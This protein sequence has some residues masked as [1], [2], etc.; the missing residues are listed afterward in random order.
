MTITV[1]IVLKMLAMGLVA[2]ALSGMVGIGG[3]VVLVPAMVIF[4][5]FAQKEAQGTPLAMLMFPVVI[6]SVINYYRS[7]DISM[8]NIKI[9]LMIG[10]G[11]IFGGYLGSKLAVSLPEQLSI[12]EYII[13]K[14]VKKVFALVVI[15]MAI[16]WLLER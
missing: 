7:G 10:A 9:A 15:V 4:L 8:W 2:G 11:F 1:D 12:G 5:G 14:P 16:R 3:G 6:L 13:T